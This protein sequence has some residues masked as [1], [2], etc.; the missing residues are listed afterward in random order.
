MN[1]NDKSE[2]EES[3]RCSEV[4]G[5]KRYQVWFVPTEKGKK[6]FGWKEKLLSG[7]ELMTEEDAVFEAY[8]ANL[9]EPAPDAR[10]YGSCKVREVSP[11]ND[12]DQRP[13]K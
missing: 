11:N 12:P 8:L 10:E 6:A 5:D 1:P 13:T 2:I 3:V 7:P 4:L 9:E